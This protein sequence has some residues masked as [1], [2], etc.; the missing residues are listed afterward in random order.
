MQAAVEAVAAREKAGG[1]LECTDTWTLTC[2]PLNM[3]WGD[4]SGS[5]HF[6][7]LVLYSTSEVLIDTLMHRAYIYGTH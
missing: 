6:D 4:T 5:G 1:K 2:L 3:H 7:T